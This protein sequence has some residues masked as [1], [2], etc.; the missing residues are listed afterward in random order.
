[1]NTKALRQKVLDLAIH[2]KLVPQ[3]PTDESAEK[4]LE[5]IR[6]EKAESLVIKETA[7]D[8]KEA[9]DMV[10]YMP[11]NFD[12]EDNAEIERLMTATESITFDEMIGIK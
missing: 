2:G 10:N 1:M 5:R 7:E 11:S 9:V 6:L 12:E 8:I 4:L 3:N